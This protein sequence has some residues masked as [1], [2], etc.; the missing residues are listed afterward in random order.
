MTYQKKPSRAYE[1]IWKQLKKRQTCVLEVIDPI[2]VTRIKKMIIKEKCRDLG[3]KVINEVDRYVLKF[4]WS[5]ESK[6][7]T[8]KLVSRY[9][10]TDIRH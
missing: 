6:E 4:S 1:S 9:G 2:F 3:F 10:L 7:L 8:I 5:Q